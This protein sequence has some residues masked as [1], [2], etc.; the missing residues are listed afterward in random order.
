MTKLLRRRPCLLVIGGEGH[1]ISR[2]I[3]GHTDWIVSVPSESHIDKVALD[4]LNV[5]VA[6]AV[7]CA[8]YLRPPNENA[9]KVDDD[10][11]LSHNLGFDFPEGDDA[12]Y[13]EYIKA[14]GIRNREKGKETENPK[15]GTRTNRK[16]ER[17]FDRLGENERFR[18]HERNSSGATSA[19]D[20]HNFAAKR[21]RPGGFSDLRED[22]RK[23]RSSRRQVPDLHHDD[24]K[25]R[26]QQRRGSRGYQNESGVGGYDRKLNRSGD[27]RSSQQKK[28][29]KDKSRS[30]AGTREPKSGKVSASGSNAWEALKQSH[31]KQERRGQKKVDRRGG[32]RRRS[33]RR[34]GA[35]N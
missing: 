24:S 7:L 21:Q 32:D 35:R 33:G 13:N 5:S 18:N 27:G 19:F 29:A 11:A 14:Q 17:K 15:T 3:R 20:K 10:D 8:E 1:G 31:E 25:G 22:G 34:K 23:E 16:Y 28:S 4:S 9:T 2:M 26:T 12:G 30:M 6:T